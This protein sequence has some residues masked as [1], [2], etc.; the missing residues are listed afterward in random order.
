MSELQFLLAVR[1][2]I[3]SQILLFERF[4]HEWVVRWLFHGQGEFFEFTLIYRRGYRSNGVPFMLS[5]TKMLFESSWVDL[6]F[7]QIP[8]QIHSTR[9]P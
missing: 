1:R 2:C 9:V 6:K 8:V 3:A 4:P 7:H 5:N